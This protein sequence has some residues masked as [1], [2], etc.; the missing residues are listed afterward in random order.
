[1][2]KHLSRRAVSAQLICVVILGLL[3]ASC[4]GGAQSETTQA[5]TDTTAGPTDTTSGPTDTTAGPTEID[6]VRIGG[7]P[8]TNFAIFQAAEEQGYLE[9]ARIELEVTNLAAGPLLMEALIGGSIDVALPGHTDTLRAATVYDDLRIIM[10]FT[11]LPDPPPE[12]NAFLVR[13][14]SGIESPEDLAGKRITTG[15]LNNI[16]H[17]YT[18]EWLELHGVDPASVQFFEVPFPNMQDA[19]DQGQVDGVF[20]VE[21]F[22]TVML[23]SGNYTNL[24]WPYNEINPGFT[25]VTGTVRQS[26]LDGNE[27]VAERLVCALSRGADYLENAEDSERNRIVSEFTGIDAALVAR[28]HL[29]V[30]EIALKEDTI[31]KTADLLLKRGEIDQPLDITSLLT[32]TATSE[33][34]TSNC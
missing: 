12:N 25:I 34:A 4:G 15:I 16:N 6:T 7:S 29:P 2:K 5:Q 28:M 31:Q 26:W 19:L 3:V 20:A 24:G 11:S 32:E 10:G 21:P 1:M 8:L 22:A 23:E 17:I 33:W 9:E 18:E 27:G 13:A 14:D 30:Y